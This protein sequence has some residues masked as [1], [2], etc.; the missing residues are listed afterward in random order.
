M[1]VLEGGGG[2]MIIEKANLFA[3]M[4]PRI[5]D[6][7][8]KGTVEES[9]EAG[10]FIFRQGDPAENLYVLLEGRIRLSLVEHGDTALMVT[11]PG[12]AFGWSSLMERDVYSTSAE[13]LTPARIGKIRREVLAQIMEQDCASA[14]I[15]Y[16]RL[17]QLISRRLLNCYKLLPAA[18]GQKTASPGG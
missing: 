15:F 10:A 1:A 14:L 2:H 5:L 8:N 4:G 11:N 13:C 12:D 9:H 3:G 6:E 7:I 16:K 18:H 17:A